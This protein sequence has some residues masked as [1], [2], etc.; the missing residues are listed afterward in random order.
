MNTNKTRILIVEDDVNLGF[1][2]E[3]FIVNSNY[4]VSRVKTGQEALLE[5][6]RNIYSLF[7]I[8]IGLPDIS[9]F[10][11]IENI[12]K[13][14]HFTPIIVITDKIEQEF[15]LESFKRKA[16]LF[17]RKPIDFVLLITQINNY[18][19]FNLMENIIKIGDL[20]FNSLDHSISNNSNSF[21]L[22]RSEFNLL[23]LF[24]SKDTRLFTRRELM[25][26]VMDR[27]KVTSDS[28]VDTLISRL[29]KKLE[30]LGYGDLIMTVHNYGY[31]LNPIYEEK[32]I[33]G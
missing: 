11:V 3:K 28:A 30:I 6:S 32:I 33:R 19:A 31:K 18:L 24:T 10:D 17:H 7:L 16:T 15:E 12:R 22:S 5:S 13:E 20:K 25:A 4:S 1:L 27:N 14:D 21:S 9:G 2:L 29:R 23:N 8:D 26:K